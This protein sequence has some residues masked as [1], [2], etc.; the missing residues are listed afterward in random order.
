MVKTQTNYP[1]FA[2]LLYALQA[3]IRKVEKP[4]SI[5]LRDVKRA[6]KIFKF[7]KENFGKFNY[8]QNNSKIIPP[9]TRSLVLALSLCY[10]FRL[11]DQSKHRE[12]RK[13][14]IYII[15]KHQK[16]DKPQSRIEWSKD[17]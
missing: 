3:F 13:E 5:R 10:L 17:F 8:V 16:I 12:Y 15:E 11:Y 6:I 7:F 2:E 14:M 9:E 1:Y 4:F